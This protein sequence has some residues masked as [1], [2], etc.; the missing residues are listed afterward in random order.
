MRQRGV[1]HSNF[2]QNI[3]AKA[4]FQLRSFPFTAKLLAH[5]DEE[6]PHTLLNALLGNIGTGRCMIVLAAF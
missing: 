5:D 6:K 4:L 3:F 2:L 1:S